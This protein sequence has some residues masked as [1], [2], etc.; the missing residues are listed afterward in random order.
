M[1]KPYL[2]ASI[3]SRTN[4]HGTPSWQVRWREKGVQLSKNFSSAPLA[5]QFA[6]KIGIVKD[7]QSV[8]A[9][10]LIEPGRVKDLI[11]TYVEVVRAKNKP[12]SSHGDQVAYILTRDSKRLGI[13]W[14]SEI[15]TAALDRLLR[16]YGDHRATL[17][18]AISTFKTFLRWA[19]RSRFAIDEWVLEYQG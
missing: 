16:S 9:S 15:D 6:K 2:G 14:T 4:R 3:R 11:P 10:S 17:K 8:M 19:R 5:E 18:K 1:A 13:Q 12:G 7:I